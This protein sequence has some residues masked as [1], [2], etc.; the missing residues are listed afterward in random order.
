MPDGFTVI[1]GYSYWILKTN[2][3]E[4]ADSKKQLIN[5][6]PAEKE[7]INELIKKNNTNFTKKDELIELVKQIE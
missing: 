2:K 4:R 1:P 3:L 6:F 5:I 7:K